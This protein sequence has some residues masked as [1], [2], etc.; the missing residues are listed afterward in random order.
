MYDRTYAAHGSPLTADTTSPAMDGR[1]RMIGPALL[2]PMPVHATLQ[3]IAAH[4]FR[5]ES[6]DGYS[7]H[8]EPV[9]FHLDGAGK[10]TRLT[11]GPN[12]SLP[13]ESW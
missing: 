4:T 13:V 2:D 8:G 5:L 1:L 10:V 6:K 11:V 3:P 12:E 7:S 9:V